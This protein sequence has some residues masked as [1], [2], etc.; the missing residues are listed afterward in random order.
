M[1]GAAIYLASPAAA[2]VTGETIDEALARRKR[3]RR[4]ALRAPFLS[5]VRILAASDMVAVLPKGIAEELERE[6]Q[7][8]SLLAE[9]QRALAAELRALGLEKRREL[10]I[11]DEAMNYFLGVPA[12]KRT[13]RYFSNR[14][15]TE[16][17]NK[18]RWR[19]GISERKAERILAT[20]ASAVVIKAQVLVGGR[21]K[22]A[23]GNR[24]VEGR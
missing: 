12:T 11:R 21:G 8:T 4:I 10:P 20:G 14:M 5:A 22:D 13:R 19:E 7:R 18:E 9:R 15:T 17:A 6:Q 2:F 24:F 23:I 16:E 1:V 3:K